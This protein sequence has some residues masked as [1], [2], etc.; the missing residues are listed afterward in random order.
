MRSAYPVD[1][2]RKAEA[3]LMSTLPEGTLM[4]RAAAGLARRCAATLEHVYGAAVVLFVGSGDNGGDALFAGAALA[5]RGARVYAALTGERAHQ[6][7]L[8][9]LRAAG[10]LVLEAADVIRA[11]DTADLVVDGVLG[12][13]GHGGLRPPADAWSAAAAAA[14]VPIISVDIPSGVDASTGRVDGAAVR[15]HVTVTFGAL[16]TGLVVTPGATYAGTVELVDIGLGPHLPA[17]A[18]A[19]LLDADDVARLL[20]QPAANSDKYRRGVV[21]VLA[22]SMSFTGAAVLVVG[23]AISAGAGMV[24][25]VGPPAPADHVR[26]RWPEAVC[27]VAEPGDVDAIGRAGRVQAWVVGSGLELDGHTAAALRAVL[28]SELPVLAD[29]GAV[30]VLR[31]HLDWLRGRPAPTLLTPHAGEFAIL[32]GTE[33]AEVEAEPLTWATR[34]AEQLGATVLLK[35]S[36]TVV[37]DP[38]L[39]VLVNPTGT[40]YLATAGSGD[41]LAGACGG[42]LAQGLDALQAGAVGA[43]LH[44]LAA[45]IAPHPLR[46]SDVIA[47]WAD[48]VSV[49]RSADLTDWPA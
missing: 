12:I 26:S 1:A 18:A 34:A 46:A 44:G 11:I 22:G 15:A 29:A 21:G 30:H 36:T 38:T 4:H 27:T 31:E 48:A 37:A 32:M 19:G 35:G 5:Q 43:Y 47:R 10:G 2:V 45:R 49:V 14:G 33:R 42:L 13:G 25:Y 3:A 20:P 41:V 6:G 23:G 40:A 7:G 8:S 28:D 16:K 9:A 39:G 17:P 24:R